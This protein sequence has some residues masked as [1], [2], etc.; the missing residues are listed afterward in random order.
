MNIHVART[1]HFRT[2]FTHTCCQGQTGSLTVRP[3]TA[4]W[5]W[6][7]DLQSPCCHSKPKSSI[8]LLRRW[9]DTVFWLCRVRYP[10][11][12][13]LG[14]IHHAGHQHIPSESPAPARSTP[15][16]D[17]CNHLLCSAKPK[18]SICSLVK[19]ADTVFWL[20][21]AVLTSINHPKRQG[22]K[23]H[24][25]IYNALWSLIHRCTPVQWGRGHQRAAMRWEWA[26]YGAIYIPIN[27]FQNDVMHCLE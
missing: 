1:P 15:R 27:V 5:R 2:R 21:T 9:A 23:T 7:I 6:S 17:Y 4:R 8:C 19:W 18:C 22:D 24:N 20:C 25:F 11:P 12:P 10:C 26:V 3:D 13:N 14:L 16:D